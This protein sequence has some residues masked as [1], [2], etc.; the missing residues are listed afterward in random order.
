MKESTHETAARKSSGIVKRRWWIGANHIGS[1][2]RRWIFKH[3]WGTIRL[4]HILRSDEGRDFHDHPFSFLSIILWGSYVEVTP[5]VWDCMGEVD[6]PVGEVGERKR[7]LNWRIAE[8][9]HRLELEKPV[10]TLVFSGRYRRDWG[11]YTKDG[12]VH[13]QDYKGEA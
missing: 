5:R 13:Y 10:W 12:W 1:Y 6:V 11:F 3:P 2:M 9:C 7:W 4:H 8:E